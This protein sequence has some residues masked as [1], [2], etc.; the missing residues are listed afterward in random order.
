MKEV[1]IM[2]RK[3]IGSFIAA[4]RKANGF[5]QQEVAD[6]LN[7]SNKAISR[8][9]RDECSPDIS[10]LTSIAE[11]FDVTTDELLKGERK[12]SDELVQ[13]SEPKA[14]KRFKALINRTLYKFKVMIYSALAFSVAGYILMLGISYGFT[15]PI[16]GFFVMM[17]FEL[18]GVVITVMAMMKLKENKNDEELFNNI[19]DTMLNKYNKICTAYSFHSFLLSFAVLVWS[20]PLVLV[21]DN[22]VAYSVMTAGSYFV[23]FYCP[24]TLLIVIIYICRKPYM[25]GLLEGKKIK[26][27]KICNNKFVVP[28]AV[29][30]MNIIYLIITILNILFCVSNFITEMDCYTFSSKALYNV[31]NNWILPICELLLSVVSIAVFILFL[32]KYKKDRIWTIFYGIRNML[33]FGIIFKIMKSYFVAYSVLPNKKPIRFVTIYWDN[34]LFDICLIFVVIIVGI[35]LK[36]Y[37]NDRVVK[38]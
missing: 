25:Y 15:R 36:R 26:D 9:E 17:L 28:N 29:K 33:F 13:R 5:T 14:E 6:K 10:L 37:I 18:T 1:F 20:L 32:K 4:L 34:I 19:E 12:A 27:I 31:L 11:I 38:K 24:I 2:E 8:W 7:V 35:I 22:V 21:R 3:T 30:R 16:V 23:N